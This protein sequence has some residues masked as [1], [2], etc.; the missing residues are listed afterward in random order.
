MQY[1]IKNKINNKNTISQANIP[2]ILPTRGFVMTKQQE[3]QLEMDFLICN[4]IY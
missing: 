2:F 4:R 1:I 3:Q